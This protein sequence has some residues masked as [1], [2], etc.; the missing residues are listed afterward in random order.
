MFVAVDYGQRKQRG[1]GLL[2]FNA[3]GYSL[4]AIRTFENCRLVVRFTL[5][6]DQFITLAQQEVGDTTIAYFK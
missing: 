3:D 6:L 2:C 4:F 1:V 5:I